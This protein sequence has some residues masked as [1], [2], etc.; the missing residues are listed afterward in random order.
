MQ[1]FLFCTQLVCV[2]CSKLIEC[3]VNSCKCHLQSYSTKSIRQVSLSEPLSSWDLAPG[4]ADSYATNL[5]NQILN[6]VANH[7]K[8]GMC[9]LS[10]FWYF[11][12]KE[13]RKHNQGTDHHTSHHKAQ[14]GKTLQ[15]FSCIKN[16]FYLWIIKRIKDVISWGSW[17]LVCQFSWKTFEFR[18]FHKSGECESNIKEQ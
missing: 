16:E 12:K 4:F 7:M 11:K 14:T 9:A 17:Y 15:G 6:A 5:P 8:N 1:L 10:T 2:D 13:G 18:T 3:R